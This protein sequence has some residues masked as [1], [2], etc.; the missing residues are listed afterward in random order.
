MQTPE[1]TIDPIPE[2]AES[3]ASTGSGGGPSVATLIGA[4]AAALAAIGFLALLFFDGPGA[5]AGDG[6]SDTGLGQSAFLAEDGSTVTLVEFQGEPLI[7]NFF[8]SWCGPCRAEMPDFE[9]VHM[10]RQDEVVFLGISHDL[11]QGT[12]KALVEETGVTFETVF[13]PQQELYT[14]LDAKGMPTTV[15][16]SP[17]GEVVYQHTGL[18]TDDRLEELIDEHFGSDL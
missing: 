15:F 9:Q 16:F 13:Q 6:V 12:W 11:D 2:P 8:A 4:G 7:V 17:T 18:L 1:P 14:A 5:D 3:S 10:A